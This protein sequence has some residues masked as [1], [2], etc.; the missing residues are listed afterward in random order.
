MSSQVSILTINIPI[1]PIDP[2]GNIESTH[3]NSRSIDL[4]Y[5]DLNINSY[6][7]G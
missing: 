7:V 3:M 6:M 5:R 2:A 1:S 4:L